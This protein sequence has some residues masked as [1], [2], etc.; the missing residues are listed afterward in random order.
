MHS[1]A[2]SGGASDSGAGSRD[3]GSR[4]VGS[5]GASDLEQRVG[6]GLQLVEQIASQL[7]RSLGNLARREDLVASGREGL[8]RAAQRFE[9][10]RGVPFRG[11]AS[12]RIRGAMIDAL[13]R[14]GQ[15]PRRVHRSLRAM[16]SGML[17]S[18]GQECPPAPS[19][20]DAERRLDEHL[21]GMATAMALGLVAERGYGEEGEVTAVASGVTPEQQL[22]N[23]Q[24]LAEVK[25]AIAELPDAEA[26][27]VRRHYFEGERFDH[28]AEELGLSKS[29]ASRLHSRAIDRLRSR[30][31]RT[32]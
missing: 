1:G 26:T 10:E 25:A 28:V 13:R 21:A 7:L 15:L 3:A 23:A 29:W 8:V 4:D 9:P 19:A 22:A 14:D 6:E 18:E 20:E 16:E 11:Y 27:L 17:Y 24:L 5:Y 31:S 30:L 12:F 2:S 32:R